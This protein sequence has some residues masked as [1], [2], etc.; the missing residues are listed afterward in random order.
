MEN[1]SIVATG[2]WHPEDEVDN[3]WFIEHFAQRDIDVKGLLHALGHQ[4][5][6]LIRNGQDTTL[7]MAQAASRLALDQAGLD[8]ED[9]DL[10]IFT[11]QTP[12]YLIPATA[13]KLHHALGA[14][15]HTL[16]YDLNANCVGMVIALDQAARAMMA[17][18]DCRSALV[19]GTDFLGAHSQDAPVY[20]ACMAESAAAV[21]LRKTAH[22]RG[23]IDARIHVDTSVIDNSLFPGNGLSNIHQP[24]LSARIQFTP[25][26]DSICV[27]AAVD[28]IQ[29]LLARHHLCAADIGGFMLSQFS[30]GNIAK[31]CARLG[32]DQEK[33][34]HVAHRFGYT[35]T[36]SPFVAFHESIRKGIIKKNDLVVFWSVGA[37]WQSAAVLMEY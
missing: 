20:H 37:G 26:D 12:E 19:V 24:G 23:I 7:T 8:A 35:A 16:A 27:D 4:K 30:I 34:P 3:E 36:N 5:R 21:I 2:L 33:A 9:L 28:S 14:A 1:V 10:I 11:S 32:V 18:P 22:G 15:S 17:R 6:Y 29:A 13:L 25:F 31:I